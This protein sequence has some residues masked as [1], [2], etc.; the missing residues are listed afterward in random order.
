VIAPDKSRGT[1]KSLQTAQPPILDLFRNTKRRPG[2][3]PAP[4]REPR[5]AVLATAVGV[6]RH[7]VLPPN[8]E[9]A[10]FTC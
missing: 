2:K 3:N 8:A 5:S 6:V 7:Y 1:T 4:S 9:A 10:W